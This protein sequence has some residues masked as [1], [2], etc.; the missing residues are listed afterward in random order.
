[1]RSR[2]LSITSHVPGTIGSERVTA[3]GTV[4]TNFSKIVKQVSSKVVGDDLKKRQRV[5]IGFCS[6]LT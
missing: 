5:K 1:M 3:S 2:W 6:S 4:L